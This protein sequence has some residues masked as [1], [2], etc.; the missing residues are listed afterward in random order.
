M[1]IAALYDIHGNLPALEAVL[2]DVEK[3]NVDCLVIGGDALSGPMPVETLLLLQNLAVPVKFI[4]GNGESDILAYVKTG[5]SKGLTPNADV[6]AKRI[7]GQ[8]SADQKA[9]LA[10]WSLNLTLEVTGLGEVLFCHAI[11]T[12]DTFIFTSVTPIEELEPIFAD[13]KVKTVVCG[14]THMQFD[15]MIA[16]TRVVNAGSVGMPF[17]QAGA[18][19]LLLDDGVEFMRTEYDLVGAAECIK[20]SDYPNAAE[21][22]ASY[23]LS[24]P[25]EVQALKM[26]TKLAATQTK[27]S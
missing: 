20:N 5:E 11:P 16:G 2:S 27:S 6:E 24:V 4:H 25:S 8:L 1:R 23:V 7:A 26:M 13:V 3:A 14:H 22:V 17:G 15:R 9:F 21:F 10:T 19:W 18:H 12:S